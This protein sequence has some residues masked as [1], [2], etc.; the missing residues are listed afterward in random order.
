MPLESLPLMMLVIFAGY[1][2]FGMRGFG[3]SPITVPVL[4]HFLSLPFVLALCS[5]L[6]LAPPPCF[7]ATTPAGTPTAGSC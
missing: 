5:A 1:V 7:S 3:A 4:P 2:V 6:D